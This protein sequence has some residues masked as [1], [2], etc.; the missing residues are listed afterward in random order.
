MCEI[1]FLQ[2]LKSSRSRNLAEEKSE[3]AIATKN[4][5]FFGKVACTN[6]VWHLLC[7]PLINCFVYLHSQMFQE[8]IN[9]I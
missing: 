8:D 1:L 3:R 4:I 5:F 6:F 2:T 9:N 7:S